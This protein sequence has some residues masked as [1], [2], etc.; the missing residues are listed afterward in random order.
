M[1]I[2]AA[3]VV[4]VVPHTAKRV[5]ASVIAS[6]LAAGVESVP[7]W[8]PWSAG[9]GSG[10]VVDQTLSRVHGFDASSRR[11][12]YDVNPWFG[13]A[14]PSAN[15]LSAPFKLTLE[16]AIDL[17]SPIDAQ[18][19]ALNMRTR[20]GLAESR[21]SADTLRARYQANRYAD[22]YRVIFGYADSVAPARAQAERLQDARAAFATKE[23]SIYQAL[24]SYLADLPSNYRARRR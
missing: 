7:A 10:A 11:F 18:F 14:L 13:S 1:L 24:G 22:V 2:N 21:A 4:P 15:L 6:N 12:L 3:L 8:D 16:F 5:H 20:P 23:D 19:L 17:G 9:G